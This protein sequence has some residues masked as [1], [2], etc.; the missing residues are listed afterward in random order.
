MHRA[1]TQPI[2][3]RKTRSGTAGAGQSL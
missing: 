3:A 2:L 1:I